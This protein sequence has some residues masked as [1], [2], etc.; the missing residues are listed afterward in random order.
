MEFH[1]FFIHFSNYLACALHFSVYHILNVIILSIYFIIWWVFLFISVLYTVKS[2]SICQFLSIL[3]GNSLSGLL[4]AKTRHPKSEGNL[5]TERCFVGLCS[6][7]EFETFALCTD[8]G[9]D[10]GAPIKRELSWPFEDKVLVV[11]I[12]KVSINLLSI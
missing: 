12:Y 1:V 11:A 2:F 9:F 3:S 5:G 8:N 4:P 7:S 10:L 6:F